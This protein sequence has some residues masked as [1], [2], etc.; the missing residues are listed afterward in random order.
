MITIPQMPKLRANEKNML[1]LFC[2]MKLVPVQAM[3]TKW[4]QEEGTNM[5]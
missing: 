4:Q 5:M 2:A 1:T 3:M